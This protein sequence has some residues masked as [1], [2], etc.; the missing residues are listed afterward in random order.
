MSEN[1][2]GSGENSGAEGGA[3]TPPANQ[4]EFNRI[5]S[6]RLNRE[7]SKYGDYSELKSKA[8]QFDQFAESQK[9][10]T[11][12]QA[13]A[14]KATEA[15]ANAVEAELAKAKAA[16]KYKNLTADDL[17]L[18][19]TG[20]PEE[21]DARAQRLSERLTPKAPD[22]DGGSRTTASGP[23]NMNDII[24]RQAGLG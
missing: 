14:L 5:I 4:E 23:K 18:L 6:E 8:Q 22:F 20:T 1:T 2:E 19:G 7:R 3:W 11:Q 12:K 21:V 17:E 15:R 13:E 24:R 9:T 10:E 16:L